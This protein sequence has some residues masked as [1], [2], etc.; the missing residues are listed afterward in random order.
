[1]AHKRTA[2]EAFQDEPSASSS[3]FG[4]R[5]MQGSG[6]SLKDCKLTFEAG[7]F[8]PSISF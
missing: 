6:K 4:H 1:M 5:E 8:N 2:T 7:L 3:S